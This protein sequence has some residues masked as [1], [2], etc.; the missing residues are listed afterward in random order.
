MKLII[1]EQRVLF[2]IQTAKE[3]ERR[4]REMRGKELIHNMIKF[5]QICAEWSEQQRVRRAISNLFSMWIHLSGDDRVYS[6]T[7]SV[8]PFFLFIA[9]E[10]SFPVRLCQFIR[11]YALASFI[12]SSSS[13]FFSC[14]LQFNFYSS[15]FLLYL[16]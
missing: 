13:A 16:K 8:S 11:F 9:V 12:N 10:F 1:Y 15:S 5:K 4:R 6:F 14:T 3:N 2:R 7:L